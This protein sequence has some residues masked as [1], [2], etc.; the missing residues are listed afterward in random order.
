M[1]LILFCLTLLVTASPCVSQEA[2]GLAAPAELRASGLLEHILPRFSLKTGVRVIADPDGAMVLAGAPPGTPVFARA[3]TVYHLRIGEDPRQQRFQDWL[4]S[5]I[6]KRTVEQFRPASGA[7]FSARFKVKSVAK[8][9]RFTGNA[10]RGAELSRHHCGRCHVT[11]PQDR[12]AGIG[13]TPSF[14][15]LRAMGDWAERFQT[16]FV[17]NP[18]PAIIQIDG[19]T[20]AFDP[21]RPPPMVPVTIAQSDFEA[22]LAYVAATEAAD[23][24]APVRMQ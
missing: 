3:D 2:P 10:A 16:F 14:M 23:L 4:L 7:P 6:G 12:M 18:H 8:L 22:I 15:A 21:Q 17:R 13:S 11:G 20:T 1:R 19:L 24:G 9:P 5:D